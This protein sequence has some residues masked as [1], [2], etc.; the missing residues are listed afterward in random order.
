MPNTLEKAGT[1]AQGTVSVKDSLTI[2]TT[3]E[4]WDQIPEIDTG[5]EVVVESSIEP[6]PEGSDLFEALAKYCAN[7]PCDYINFNDGFNRKIVCFFIDKSTL[8]PEDILPVAYGKEITSF[9]FSQDMASYGTFASVEIADINGSLTAIAENQSSLYFVAGIIELIGEPELE[10]GYMLQPYIFEIEDVVSMSADGDVSK[11]YRLELADVI[12]A[13]LRK[14]SYGNLLLRYPAFSNC[15][16]FIDA[17]RYLI[18]FASSIITMNHNKKYQIDTTFQFADVIDSLLPEI[19]QNVVLNNI[20]LTTTCYDMMNVLYTHAAAKIPPPADFAGEVPGPVLIPLFLQ[21]EYEDVAGMYR[22]FWKATEHKNIGYVEFKTKDNNSKEYQMIKRGFYCKDLLMPFE[23]AFNGESEQSLIYENINPPVNE[24]GEIAESESIFSPANGIMLSP[25]TDSVDIPPTNSL[26]G[27][28]WKNLALL[29]E[30]PGGS[31]NMII[32]WNWIYE[33]FK[34]AFLNEKGSALY[35]KLHKRIQ[36]VV[37]PHFHKMEVNKLDG[38]DAEDFAKI[39]S[40]TIILKSSEPLQ[41]ALYHVGRAVKSYVFMNS[42][43]GFR[44]KGST[45]RHPGEIIKIN[46]GISE[47]DEESPSAVVGGLEAMTNKFVLAY[48]T[49]VTHIF[50]GNSYENVIYANKICSIVN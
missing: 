12:S 23:M 43:F 13:T 37:D 9:T 1:L 21:D 33:Y 6:A 28:G 16:T 40:N 41:E 2:P 15:S 45:F 26:V 31:S 8:L 46:S 11:V 19:F 50:N 24:K 20:P 18:D 34:S 32:L 27:L 5:V 47:A 29:S 14:V 44:I 49:S 35:R 30:N 25:I 3:P 38:G 4:I 17:Y 39:N 42:M 36:P 22:K 7:L 48:T 10:E